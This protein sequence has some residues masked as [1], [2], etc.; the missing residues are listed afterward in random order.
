MRSVSWFSLSIV[1]PIFTE[2]KIVKAK[3][4]DDSI[5]FVNIVLGLMQIS[6]IDLY[7]TVSNSKFLSKDI[8]TDFRDRG[9]EINVQPLSF[10]EYVNAINPDNISYA[11]NEYMMYGGIP[12][13]LSFNYD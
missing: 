2:N 10:L 12:L 9:D 8:M 1:N 4:E 13:V 3:T 11:L 6:N 5:T 7:I